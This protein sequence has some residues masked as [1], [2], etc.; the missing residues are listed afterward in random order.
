MEDEKNI[1]IERNNSFGDVVIADEVLAIIAG[2]AATEVEGVHSMDGGWSGQFIS[3][4]GIKDLARG[5]KVQ[6]REGEVKVDLSLNMEYGYA[7][8][9]VSDLVQDKVSASIN[10]MTGLTVSEVNIRISGVVN[11]ENE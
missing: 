11:K 5:V 9:K 1:Q 7:I 6:V 8:P 3:K 2:I 10:N 4:L